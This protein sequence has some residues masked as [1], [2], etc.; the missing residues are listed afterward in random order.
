MRGRDLHRKDVGL[1]ANASEP[2]VM[3]SLNPEDRP[4]LPVFPQQEGSNVSRHTDDVAQ[5]RQ[6][7]R[8]GNLVSGACRRRWRQGFD[9]ADCGCDLPA[10]QVHLADQV[11]PSLD[12]G[13][14]VWGQDALEYP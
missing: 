5:Q 1:R 3:Q 7:G 14:F 13:Q 9:L 2:P 4:V 11:D 8:L 6:P 10:N 12:L